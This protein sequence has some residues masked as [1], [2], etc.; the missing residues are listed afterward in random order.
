MTRRRIVARELG[1]LLVIAALS[2][3]VLWRVTLGGR[4]MVPGDLLLIMEPWKHH[5]HQFPEFHRVGNPILDAIQQFYPWRKYAGESLRAGVIPLWNPYELCG[6]PFVG[7]DQS[8]VFYPETWLHALLPTERALG[9]ATA[10]H[11]F[12]AGALMYWFLRV[13][14]L[15]RRAALVGAV[16]FMFNGFFV[17]WLCFPSFRSVPA[18]LPG[19]LAA[20]ELT[21]QR[22]QWP[23]LAICSA[24]VALQFLAGNLHISL[25]VMIVI[26][27]CVAFRGVDVV[28]SRDWRTAVTLVLGALAAV[29]AGGLIA[30]LQLLPVVE[31]AP[32]SSRAGGAP[33]AEMLKLATPW[34]LLLTALMPDLFGNPVD[35]NHW[36]ATLGPVYR[37][38]TE[39]AWYVGVLPLLVAP[40]AFCVRPRSRAWFWLA[41]ALLGLALAFG[42][43]VY[44]LFYYLVPGAKALSGLGRA[45][46]ISSTALPILGALGLDG[47]LGWSAEGR[48]PRVRK[49]AG[50]AALCLALIG[51]IGGGLVWVRTGPLEQVPGL[52]GIGSYTSHQIARLVLLLA[53]GA[54]LL[55]LL[56]HKRRLAAIGLVLLLSVDLY[57]FV[58]KFTPATRREY[59]HVNTR[60]VGLIRQD[61][62]PVRLL[63]VGPDPIQ[64]RMPPNTGMIFGLQDIQGSDS[65]EIGAYRRLLGALS[66]DRLAPGFPQPDPSLPG[67]DPL[68]ATYVH[69]GVDLGGIRGLSLLPTG[70]GW[71]Y[72]NEEALPRASLVDAYV[73]VADGEAALKRLAD[74][75][76]DPAATAIFL[77]PDRPERPVS[78][79]SH[80]AEPVVTY[81]GPNR[82]TVKAPVF[83]AGQLVLLSDTYYP[84]WHAFQDGRECRVLRADYALRAVQIERPC[85]RIDFVYSPVSFRAGAFASLCGLAL[86]AGVG[87]YVL[88][89]RGRDRP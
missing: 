47:L 61:I 29:L 27:A 69:S 75:E 65:L 58:S 85:R 83:S 68:G 46:L 71:L 64:G 76:L 49:Y 33:Y 21:A 22:R 77:A 72:R 48:A 70:E 37:A 45:I 78:I 74:R 39:T 44:A 88:S 51:L 4:A 52:E 20:L 34:P 15:R 56:P 89:R 6:N 86:L 80:G 73:V 26:A 30:A 55:A 17:G 54:G 1:P 16:A 31:L 41:M 40:A 19:A 84:G 60:T 43:P 66:S 13:L 23:W 24:C 12:T 38:Y 10:L 63:S 25:L 59:L 28:L 62:E 2:V 35:Y 32:M 67:L 82:A 57:L 14:R 18:W 8:A 5:A 53:L 87:G 11:F 42:T 9:W 36:G 3:G 7:N 50:L 81:S 79:A